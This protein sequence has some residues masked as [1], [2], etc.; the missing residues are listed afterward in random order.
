MQHKGTGEVGVL[1]KLGLGATSMQ[2]MQG[3]GSGGMSIEHTP[4]NES[5]FGLLIFAWWMEIQAVF[6]LER[7]INFGGMSVV[8]GVES[9]NTVLFG[10]T[11][12][13]EWTLGFLSRNLVNRLTLLNTLAGLAWHIL[14]SRQVLQ[15]LAGDP[16]CGWW[17]WPWAGLRQDWR[18]FVWD[19][20]PRVFCTE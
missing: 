11:N 13:R 9:P 4:E 1:G 15:S 17:K 3:K 10:L 8:I 2:Y 5:C 12:G 14:D 6:V 18:D 7:L 16:N 20:V 19:L